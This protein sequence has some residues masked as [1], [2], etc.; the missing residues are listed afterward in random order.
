MAEIP[1]IVCHNMWSVFELNGTLNLIVMEL[2]GLKKWTELSSVLLFY[3]FRAWGL[4]I[5]NLR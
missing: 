4:K 2:M 1:L 3:Y 5:D